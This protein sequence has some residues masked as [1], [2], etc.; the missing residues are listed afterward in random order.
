MK[1]HDYARST[2]TFRIDT[3]VKPPITASHQPPFS[4]NN[5]RIVLESAMWVTDER[6]GRTRR[7]VHGASCKTEKV[8]VERDIWLKPNA[9]FIPIASE[10]Q[11]LALKTYARQGDSMPLWPPGSGTQNERQIASLADAY[12][13]FTVDMAEVDGEVLPDAQAIVEAVLAGERL[14]ART[15]LHEGPYTA[16]IEYPVKT[17][18]ANERDWVYQTDTGPHLFP[19]LSR[20]PD[21]LLAG[22]QLAFSAFNVFEWIEF[23]VR[24]PTEI[25]EGITVWHYSQPVRRDVTNEMLRIP[26]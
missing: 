18:N 1:T 14:V 21:D 11:M 22:V 16:V 15:T 12:A 4:L 20:R 6:D 23:I 26:R 7:F 19:D 5:A 3:H 17:I 25:A 2:L 24:A 8:G 9:D 13:A 10:E